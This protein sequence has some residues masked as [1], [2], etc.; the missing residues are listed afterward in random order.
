MNAHDLVK[1]QRTLD[2][3]CRAWRELGV[4]AFDTEFI[5][6]NTY[7]AALCLVQVGAGGEVVL[8]DPTDDLD[9][10][11][12]WELVCDENITTIIHAGK[13]D[14]EL[15]L[16]ATG[17]PPRNVFDV[18]IA[19]GFVGYS[20]PLSLSRLVDQVL[21]R[22]VAKGQTLTDWARRPL[23]A[24]QIRYAIEDVTHLCAVYEKL[25]A[26]LKRRRRLSWVAEE[27]RRF[28]DPLF[29]APPAPERVAKLKGTKRL[30]GLGLVVI[31]A[32]I[33]WRHRWAKERNRPIRALMRDDVLVEIARR[34]PKR[35]ADLA[36]LRGFPQSRNSKV[37][38][39]LL[40]V[41]EQAC[42][43]PKSEWPEPHRSR[44]ETPMTK[45]TL[46]ILSAVTRALCYEHGVSHDLLGGARRLRELLDYHR[47]NN[48]ERPAL[49]TG[50]REK[51]AGQRLIALLEG[52]SEV[53]LSGWPRDTRLEIVTHA[54]APQ[55]GEAES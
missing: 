55:D 11:V 36:V 54:E 52:R 7:D 14:F 51:F 30:D 40:T 43:T 8:I 29:Y 12:F 21:H 35:A 33:E 39:E 13:E 10:G 45:A 41:I 24:E 20:Y 16:R 5:R 18:Q 31:G 37:V 44:E 48:S 2:A 22:R 15:C 49:L 47:D 23:T 38:K 34:R 42:Q 28:E 1:D 32:L 50:W 46:D 19:A 17:R 4:F 26:R 6:D 53:H 9:L 27:F 3:R 25:S